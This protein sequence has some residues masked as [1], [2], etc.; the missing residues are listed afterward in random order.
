MNLVH[1]IPSSDS[2]SLLSSASPF[3][4]ELL[5]LPDLLAE[6]PSA[7]EV[8]VEDIVSLYISGLIEKIEDLLFGMPTYVL[9]IG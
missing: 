4:L 7:D 6:V 5:V 9:N 2:D 1:F 8:P 3:D